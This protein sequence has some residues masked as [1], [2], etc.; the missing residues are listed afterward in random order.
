MIKWILLFYCA[1]NNLF[2]AEATLLS[3]YSWNNPDPAFGGFSSIHISNQGRTFLATS[4]K[5]SF[6]SGQIIRKNDK[7]I[8][9]T[10][11][12]LTPLHNATKKPL[13][14]KHADSEGI[15]LHPDGRIFV[16]FEGNHRIRVY[17]NRYATAKWVPKHPDFKS[18]QDNSSLEALAIDDLG[19]LYT[20][21]ERSGQKNKPFPVYRYNGQKWDKDFSIPRRG[22]FLVVGADFGPDGKFYLL[23]RHFQFPIGF[24]T[25]VRRFSLSSHGFHSEKVIIESSLGAHGNLEGISVWQ[26]DQSR[27]RVTLI[28]DDNFKFFQR[29]QLVEYVVN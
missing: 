7:I 20:I 25:R 3:S 14:G 8:K 12:N 16:S 15:A 24:I 22:E 4:D 13:K 1:A 18:M 23:E 6:L 2:A 29:T 27:I 9:I 26:D 19:Q 28:A 10:E 17:H 21:P 5:A 11:Q